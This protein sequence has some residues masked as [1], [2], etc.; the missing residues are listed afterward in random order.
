VSDEISNDAREGITEALRSAPPHPSAVIT[1]WAIVVE[2]A[3]PNGDFGISKICGPGSDGLPSW[4]AA[5]MYRWAERQEWTNLDD[6]NRDSDAE[7]GDDHE[8]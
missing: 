8:P 6:A 4:K 5:G 3:A 7:Y 2:Y 1:G